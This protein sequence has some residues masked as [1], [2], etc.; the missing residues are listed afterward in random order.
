M[1]QAV[2]IAEWGGGGRGQPLPAI[3]IRCRNLERSRTRPRIPEIQVGAKEQEHWH[4][5]VNTIGQDWHYNSLLLAAGK[6]VTLHLLRGQLVPL[7]RVIS[8]AR[9]CCMLKA[10]CQH[11]GI[12]G[13]HQG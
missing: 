4:P 2:L 8:A 9:Q 10:E 6:L 13:T 7:P 5:Q 11:S 1:G 12:Q 3:T